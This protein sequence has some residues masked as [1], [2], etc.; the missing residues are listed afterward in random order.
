MRRFVATFGALLTIAVPG[1]ARAQGRDSLPD[2]RLIPTEVAQEVVDAFNAPGVL[3]STGRLDIEASRT[4]NGDVAVL[5]GPVSIAG[6]V[7]GRVV[8]INSDVVLSPGARVEGQILIVGGVLEGKDDAFIGGDVRVYR[9][10]LDYRRDGERIVAQGRNEIDERWWRRRQQRWRSRTYTDLRLFSARTYNRVEGLPILI[11]PSFIKRFPDGRFSLEAFGI[12]RT[13][14][15]EWNSDNIGHSVK[16]EMRVGRREGLALGGK[17]FDTVDPVEDW[18]LTDTEVGLASFFLHRDFRD[19]FDRHGGSGSLS[20]FLGR[21]IDLTAT[22]SDEQ[23]RARADGDPFTLFRN[24]DTWRPNPL[25]D[26]GR[27][28]VAT[29]TL[30]I[31]TRN[32]SDHPWSGWYLVGEVERGTG[33]IT[34][35]GATTPGVRDSVVPGPIQYDRGFLDI[36]RYNRLA[37]DAQ[38]N[39]RFV[40]GGWLDGD[41]LPLQ[42]RFAL[43]G[44]GSLPGYDFRRVRLDD[45]GLAPTDVGACA[46]PDGPPGV[47]GQCERMMLAQAEYRGDLFFDLFGAFDDWDNDGWDSDAQWVV[48]ADAGR[49]WLVG[50]R[51]GDLTYPKDMIPPL[52]TWRSDVGIG[53]TFGSFGFY[54][55]KAV[56]DSKEPPNFFIRIKRR[57]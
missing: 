36:R 29:G 45:D 53:L 51:N 15:F 11:G 21:D 32:D 33:S 34:S 44:P 6:I 27:L 37:P 30:R 52:S 10:R 47:P 43:G 20:L 49:G 28:H 38:F 5:H 50:P 40:A 35:Y 23:W 26:E 25:L 7:T 22:L 42:K 56:S 12:F 46:G 8:A 31:D 14:G 57:F 2:P 39:L 9:Q 55:A 54:V 4:V 17:L 1:G 13:V 48:F 24:K 41:E 3:R 19:Y 18:Q 16:A